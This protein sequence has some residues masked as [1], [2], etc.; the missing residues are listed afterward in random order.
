MTPVEALSTATRAAGEFL[1][2]PL[3]YI[4]KGALADLVICRGD[5]LSRIEDAAAVDQIMKNGELFDIPTLIGPFLKSSK[6]AAKMTSPITLAAA[7]Q[8]WWHDADYIAA[9]RAACC[10]DPFCATPKG[11][12]TFIATEA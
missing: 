7:D 2:Q 12:R 8:P 4:S 11:R 5:P 6:Q 9:G 3:G 10:T 1:D